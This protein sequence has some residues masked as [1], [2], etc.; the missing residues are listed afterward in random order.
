M[1][2]IST[3]KAPLALGHYE[4][5]IVHQGLV[6]VSG[7]LP[8]TLSGD[9]PEGIEAQTKQALEN[10]KAILKEAGS[11]LNQVLK[12]T[13]FITDIALW[14]QANQVYASVFGSHKPAR[15]AVPVQAL[16]KGALIEIEAIASLVHCLT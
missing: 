14:S 5:A 12:A 13:I 1:K 10:L 7:Q 6:F 11:E 9:M 15:S 3:T 2:P 16:P 8:L 4:Q